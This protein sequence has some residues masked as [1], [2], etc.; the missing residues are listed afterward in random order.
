MRQEIEIEVVGL[1]QLPVVVPLF[2]AYR[3]FYEKKPNLPVA[4]KFLRAR[5]ENAESVIFLARIEGQAVGFT[6][7]YPTFSSVSAQTAWILNDLYVAESARGRGVGAALLEHA[8]RYAKETGAKGLE[9]ATAKDN[10]TAQRLY[11]R[12]G[13]VRE[14]NFYRY[15]L[16][17]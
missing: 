1:A 15:E 9:L 7:L 12:L 13:W 6:Q 16:L 4:E 2:D 17:V 8:A 5:L 3:R 11:E 10:L 14:D